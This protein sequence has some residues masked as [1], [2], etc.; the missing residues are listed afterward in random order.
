LDN[1]IETDS[2]LDEMKDRLTCAKRDVSR[3]NGI[4]KILVLDD[5]HIPFHREEVIINIVMKHRHEIDLIVFGGDVVDCESVSTFPKEI[6][7]P[8][9]EEMAVTYK[10]LR[11]I[12]KLTPDIGKVLFWGNHEYRFVRFLD[13]MA[14]ALNPF[15][16]ANI[17]QE[18]VGGFVH[19]DRGR[20]KK[21]T[22][23]PLS[24]NFTVFDKWYWQL[25]DHIFAHPMDFSKV[26]LKTGTNAMEHFMAK[27]FKFKSI[28]IGH[29][30]KWGMVSK[31]LK[32]ITET[33]CLCLP[34]DYMDTGKLGY[35]RQDYGY[36]LLTQVDGV[37]DINESKLYKLDLEDGDVEWLHVD[38]DQE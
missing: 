34:M 14:T 32:W 2:S 36:L 33:G 17:L 21:T 25:G 3:L 35:T 37:T 26:S 7:K 5:L 20:K 11:K 8:L 9:I 27:G 13:K 28:S 10:F 4:R 29:T 12:D 24:D 15:H 31:S 18:I 16:S 22:Y 23:A 6:R 19:H 38:A 30:H 1:F